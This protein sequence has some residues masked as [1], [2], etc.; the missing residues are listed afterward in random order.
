MILNFLKRFNGLYRSAGLAVL[1][2][3]GGLLCSF[4][5]QSIDEKNTNTKIKAIFL[6]NFTKYIEWPSDYKSGMFKI[7]ILGSTDMIQELEQ[8]ASKK[9]VGAQQIVIS[10]FASVDAITKCH[11]IYIP[12]EK[13]GTLAEVVKKVGGNSTLIITDKEGSARKGA[14]IN[15]VVESNKQRFELNVSNALKHNLKVSSNLSGL[16]IVVQ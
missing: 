5:P 15:F 10:K 7:G 16:A 8:M 13:S 14:A 3:A 4:H 12:R 11:M 2:I 6:Y 1:L 9:K